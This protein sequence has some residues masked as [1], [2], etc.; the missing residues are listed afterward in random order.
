MPLLEVIRGSLATASRVGDT[1]VFP[2]VVMRSPAFGRTQVKGN[3]R[4]DIA[5]AALRASGFACDRT[6]M[7]QFGY[8]GVL[9]DLSS[10][11]PWFR[12]EIEDCEDKI[13]DERQAQLRPMYLRAN[14]Q[15]AEELLAEFRAMQRDSESWQK[16]YVARKLKG[17]SDF[18]DFAND[19]ARDGFEETLSLARSIGTSEFGAVCEAVFP[20]DDQDVAIGAPDLLVWNS[21]SAIWFFAEV[22]GPRDHLRESQV[23]WLRENWERIGGRFV[24]LI[25]SPAELANA[26]PISKEQL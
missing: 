11:A 13:S 2:T 10:P 12:V 16:E 7:D 23:M 25:L 15:T 22:K 1:I 6:R 8:P 17:L 24:L 5:I 3:A 21:E 26:G 14:E 9:R 4:A 18:I 19:C 20:V